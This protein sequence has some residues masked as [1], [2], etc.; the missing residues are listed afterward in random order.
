MGRRPAVR[1]TAEAVLAANGLDTSA[2]IR[3]GRKLV[4]PGAPPRRG[5]TAVIERTRAHV[6]RPGE[7]VTTIARRYGVSVGSVLRRNHLRATSTIQPGRRLLVA[8][9]G[10]AARAPAAA[11]DAPGRPGARRSRRRT[12]PSAATPAP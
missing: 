11:D 10:T 8:G 1:R 4:L 3:P 2:P 12:C 6:V 9:A 7:T 5:A